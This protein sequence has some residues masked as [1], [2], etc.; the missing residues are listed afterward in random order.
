MATTE[1]V[2]RLAEP[3]SVATSNLD[4]WYMDDSQEDQRLPHRRSPNEAVSLDYLKKLGVLY[5]RV[6]GEDDP[7]LQVIRDAR[8][9]SYKDVI[10]VSPEKLPNYEQKIKSFFEEHLHTDEEI[11]F[12]LEGS[13]YFDVR[14]FDERWIRID[15]RQGDMIVLP[16]GIYH[17]FTLDSNNYIKAMR[18]FVGEPVWTP[19]NRPIDDHTSRKKYVATFKASESFET[20][21]SISSASPIAAH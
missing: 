14:D 10:T 21:G 11:R 6:D 13:G 2:G 12:V 3:D 20:P 1:D 15:C 9:Y 18:L 17:R 5:W 7:K 8:G 19:L 16:E 4:A